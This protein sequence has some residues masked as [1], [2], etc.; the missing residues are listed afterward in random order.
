MKVEPPSA[1]FAA[2]LKKFGE[3]LTAG[4]TKRAGK[5]GEDI[6]AAFRK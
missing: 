6:V 3:D 2:G 4:W 5:E 1:A